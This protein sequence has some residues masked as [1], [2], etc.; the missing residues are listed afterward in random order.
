MAR[1][2]I[3]G[4]KDDRKYLTAIFYRRVTKYEVCEYYNNPFIRVEILKV[5]LEDS[6]K[7]EIRILNESGKRLGFY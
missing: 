6:Y 7:P 2:K 5:G 4:R 3:T 1:R